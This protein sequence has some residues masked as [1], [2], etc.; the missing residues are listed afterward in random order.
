M[1]T[2]PEN[3]QEIETEAQIEMA[4]RLASQQAE[5][6]F[7]YAAIQAKQDRKDKTQR[8]TAELLQ[9][10]RNR[11][12]LKLFE[13]L[14]H[15][16]SSSTLCTELANSQEVEATFGEGASTQPTVSLLGATFTLLPQN[17]YHGS[18]RDLVMV[19][20]CDVAACMNP[21]K[22]FYSKPICS[23]ADIGDVLTGSHT[24]YHDCTDNGKLWGDD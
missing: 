23:L 6:M 17:G 8:E 16:F 4:L 14:L 11:M 9:Q 10:D 18:G 2:I 3:K 24:E 13:K 19:C 20:W 22:K 7:R 12:K 21:D 15:V 1:N 5:A